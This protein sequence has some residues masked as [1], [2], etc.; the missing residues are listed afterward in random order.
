VFIL[1]QLFYWMKV[2]WN[3]TIIF[4]NG[5]ILK[6]CYAV[7]QLVEAL[8]LLVEALPYKPEVPWFDCQWWL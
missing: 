5:L 8:L 6:V 2:S 4:L 7:A 1:D 3:G